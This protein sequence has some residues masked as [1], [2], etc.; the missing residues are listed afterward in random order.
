MLPVWTFH[1]LLDSTWLLEVV[2]VAAGG[3]GAVVV[4]LSQAEPVDLPGHAVA[5][6]R[7]P[8]RLEPGVGD[9]DAGAEVL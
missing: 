1:G 7:W 6:A 5:L 9:P 4:V 8:T 3:E 2:V